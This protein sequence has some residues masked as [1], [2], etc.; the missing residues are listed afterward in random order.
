MNELLNEIMAKNNIP[1]GSSLINT[2]PDPNRTTNRYKTTDD[3]A[4]VKEL[5]NRGWNV[6][7]Y[8]QIKAHRSEKSGFKAYM[9]IYQNVTE[10][11]VPDA[12]KITIV[13]SNSR[14]GTKP[15]SLAVGLYN[16]DTDVNM[17]LGDPISY[18]HHGPIPRNL[19]ESLVENVLST[20]PSVIERVRRLQSVEL[21]DA[22]TL[23]F[24]KE[25][26]AIR[27]PADKYIFAPKDILKLRGRKTGRNT[28]WDVL[29]RIQE[30]L[31]KTEGLKVMSLEGTY[32]KARP[33]TSIGLEMALNY[34]LFEL[35]ERF[36]A[37]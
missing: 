18:K 7:E 23:Q 13:Q 20:I 26:A 34:Q 19:N 32:R 29:C 35:A 11:D 2:T 6:R 15:L 14:D 10:P 12:G 9:A 16:P 17:V 22:Q 5:N 36:I 24:A 31:L 33:I 1:V 4:L 21:D 28:L 30:R 27:F 3:L 25:A 37:H 8:R